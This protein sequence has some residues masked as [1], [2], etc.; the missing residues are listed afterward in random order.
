MQRDFD[1]WLEQIGLDD[2]VQSFADAAVD[3]DVVA[4]LTEA[5]LE[6]LGLPAWHRQRFFRAAASLGGAR[7]STAAPDSRSGLRSA[8]SGSAPTI[9]LVRR[10]MVVLFADLTGFTRLSTE[11]DPEDLQALVSEF[12]G[13]VDTQI[14]THGGAVNKYL[15]DGVMALFSATDCRTVDA[16]RAVNAALAI[17][18]SLVELSQTT[19][20]PLS[21]HIGIAAGVVLR[22]PTS[23]E[24]IVV[25]DTVNLASRLA[26]LAPSRETYVS[27]TV[28]RD[29]QQ[30]F[31]CRAQPTIDV[32]GF[33][34]PVTVWRVSA[35]R[36][37]SWA[38]AD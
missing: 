22:G 12:L 8:A 21:A 6:D 18:A 23:G 24:H 10:Q 30:Q 36:G 31:V 38:S 29:V 2:F 35:A 1:H 25:G 28:F 26:D 3:F 16:A 4:E 20:R 9:P 11:L 27:E 14:A 5:D 13:T 7:S 15:G 32:K 17:H 19:M 34:A 33:D 37:L